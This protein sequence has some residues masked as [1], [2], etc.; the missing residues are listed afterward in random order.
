MQPGQ[1]FVLEDRA[2]G[3]HG[4][5]TVLEGQFEDAN[6]V[7]VKERLPAGEVILLDS[8]PHRFLEL[9]PYRFQIEK[10][11]RMI[12]RTATDEA[13]AAREV[14]KGPRDLEPEIV[15]VGKRH[16]GRV[17][18]TIIQNGQ[19]RHGSSKGVRLAARA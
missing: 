1:P 8:K 12:V 16:A 18:G 10:T 17:S 14:A 15:E 11:E 13:V 2:V 7:A 6:H 5:G 4:G 19:G 9:A 3:Q